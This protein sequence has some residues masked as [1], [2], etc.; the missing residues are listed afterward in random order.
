MNAL[1]CS[2]IAGMDWL[3]YFN[4]KAHTWQCPLMRDEDYHRTFSYVDDRVRRFN[5]Y[6]VGHVMM[7]QGI[8]PFIVL[9]T[10]MHKKGYLHGPAPDEMVFTILGSEGKFN[11]KVF[12]DV[13]KYYVP[14]HKAQEVTDWLGAKSQAGLRLRAPGG[15]TPEFHCDP[16]LDLG[17][18]K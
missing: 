2:G 14:P 18:K 11:F 7:R 17:A 13:S 3:V 10:E 8:Y 4:S 1:Y 16:D 12:N 5:K 9:A 6:N 15:S